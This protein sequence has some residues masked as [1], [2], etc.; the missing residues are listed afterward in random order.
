MHITAPSAAPA[1]FVPAND[2]T[3]GPVSLPAPVATVIE[4]YE[5]LEAKRSPRWIC[6]VRAGRERRGPVVFESASRDP[7]RAL[8]RAWKWCTANGYELVAVVAGLQCH[9]PTRQQRAD[10]A[11]GGNARWARKLRLA[12]MKLPERSLAQHTRDV[13]AA[14]A[15]AEQR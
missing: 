7:N 9:P 10:A 5:P 12:G 15:D 2:T 13:A 3:A 4:T 14:E 11:R 8:Y 1:T 6:T